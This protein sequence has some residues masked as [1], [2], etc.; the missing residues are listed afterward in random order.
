MI[1][2]T[3]A[4]LLIR[5]QLVQCFLDEELRRLGGAPY[6]IATF[7]AATKAMKLR[8]LPISRGMASHIDSED[9]LEV[10]GQLK[11]KHD[12]K[13]LWLWW[14]PH[15]GGYTMREAVQCALQLDNFKIV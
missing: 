1:K 14:N 5:G 3:R 8:L 2:W 10:L 15:G 4:Q 13:S 11:W 6:T 7:M 12:E 9:V